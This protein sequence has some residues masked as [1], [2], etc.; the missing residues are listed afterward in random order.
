MDIAVAKLSKLVE[1]TIDDDDAVA[2]DD[3]DDDDNAPEVQLPNVKAAVLAKVIEYCEHY[4]TEEMTAISTPLKS[5]K[6]EDLV[7]PYYADYVKLEQTMLFELVTAANF[8]DVKP[9][10]DLTC[11]AVSIMIKGKSAEELRK[12]FNLSNG[13]TPE[14]EAAVR[15]ENKWAEQPPPPPQP[16]LSSSSQPPPPPPPTSSS[17]SSTT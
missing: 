14:E 16:P 6:L 2:D 5:S 3:D 8:M 1:S 17:S 9:L 11:L 7:Q 10:L 13:F 12:M 4:Q 15:E